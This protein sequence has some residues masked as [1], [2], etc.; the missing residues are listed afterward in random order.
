MH[1]K[2]Q[3]HPPHSTVQEVSPLGHQPVHNGHLQQQQ[4]RDTTLADTQ[5]RGQVSGRF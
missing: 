1:T 4:L 5:A 2:P 3:Q